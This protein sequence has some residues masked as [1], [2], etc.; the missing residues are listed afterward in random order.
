MEKSIFFKHTSETK[1]GT[2]FILYLVCILLCWS[3]QTPIDGVKQIEIETPTEIEMQSAVDDTTNIDDST[4]VEDPTDADDFTEVEDP[5]D[6]DD[7]KKTEQVSLKGTKWKLVKILIFAPG[8]VNYSDHNIIYEFR[9]DGILMISG[10]LEDI[11]GYW[12]PESGKH[13]YSIIPYDERFRLNIVNDDIY[14]WGL[15]SDKKLELVS[16]MIALD[17]PIYYFD[18]IN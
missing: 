5:T 15:I 4:E 17:G 11:K 6:A 3:C 18:K 1:R 9:D 2:V 10:V 14:W 16:S 7:F 13:A 8:L 12:G